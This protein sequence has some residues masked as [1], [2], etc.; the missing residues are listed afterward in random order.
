[1]A[2]KLGISR[3]EMLRMREQGMSNRD[4]AKCLEIHVATVYNHIGPQGGAMEN[5][6]AFDEP[7]AKAVE[8][9]K[10]TAKAVPRAVD[11]LK[12]VYEVLASADGEFRAEVDWENK[13]VS[14]FDCTVSFEQLGALAIFI[15]GLAS[16]IEKS[17][18]N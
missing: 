12:S 18:N 2:K 17:V 8:T 5:M 10:E 13:C 1:M 6:A 16:K 7:K 9:P 14:V 4:I 3:S 15:V 11:S